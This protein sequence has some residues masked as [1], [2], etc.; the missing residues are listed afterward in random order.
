MPARLPPR[1]TSDVQETFSQPR[2][3]NLQ[4]V[5]LSS[6]TAM[7]IQI[8]PSRLMPARLPPRVTSDVQESF[9]QPRKANLLKGGLSV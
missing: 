6:L 1:V 4:Y 2:K 7:R 9:S 8:C 5:G 3:A